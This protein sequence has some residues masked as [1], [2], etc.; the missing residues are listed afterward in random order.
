[1]KD[2]TENEKDI[3]LEKIMEEYGERLTKLAYNYV[4]DWS[5]AQDVVQDVFV[6]CYQKYDEVESILSVKSWIYR[7]TINRCKDIIKSSLF[8]RVI[9]NSSLFSV[10][11][12]K[13][14]G[15]DMEIIRKDEQELLSLSVLSLSIKYREILI[16]YYYEELSIDEISEL[17]HLNANTVKT[18][19]TRGR[20]KVKQ[21]LE[22]GGFN[23]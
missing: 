22:R 7:I 4:K 11:K 23:G 15:P 13:E 3:W 18:R 1:M 8:Q 10:F 9:V 17:L 16:L 2:Q 14:V 21:W 5:L 6:T 20:G 12:S 19:L